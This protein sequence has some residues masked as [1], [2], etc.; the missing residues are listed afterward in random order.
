MSWCHG[1]YR[2]VRR[3]YARHPELRWRMEWRSLSSADQGWAL[4]TGAC[5][6]GNRPGTNTGNGFLGAFQFTA[7]TARAAGFRSLP[8]LTSWWEQAV[9]AVRWRN[10]AGRGQ[11]PICG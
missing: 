10:I 7:P 11:W 5:E 6:S 2:C 9:R 4:A 8:H 3:A 1:T